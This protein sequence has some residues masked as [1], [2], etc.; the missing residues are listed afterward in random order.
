MMT[1]IYKLIVIIITILLPVLGYCQF[2]ENCMVAEETL[3]ELKNVRISNFNFFDESCIDN[4]WK[5]DF[6]T[7][8]KKYTKIISEKAFEEQ[9]RV[10]NFYIDSKKYAGVTNKLL[11][12]KSNEN[13]IKQI[14]QNRIVKNFSNDT[15]DLIYS[16]IT[17][18]YRVDYSV[19]NVLVAGQLL[20]SRSMEYLVSCLDKD[21]YYQNIV[22]IALNRMEHSEHLN[23]Y[24]QYILKGFELGGNH[25]PPQRW[26]DNIEVLSYI[27]TPQAIQEL[28]DALSVSGKYLANQVCNHG[29]NIKHEHKEDDTD[30]ALYAAVPL[31]NLRML[32]KNEDFQLLFGDLNNGYFDLTGYTSEIIENAKKWLSKNV[33]KLI[34]D[35]S[36]FFDLN[37]IAY[38]GE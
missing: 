19:Y 33:D 35:K 30:M 38:L 17:N 32:I 9:N 16:Q 28:I 37:R 26:K 18:R 27:G 34:I 21:Q 4:K 15:L 3:E 14:Q 36:I 7:T 31:I 2:D 24:E 22:E 29:P 23:I 11:G 20:D 8:S 12:K 6:L 25:S 5:D 1:T 13:F 10:L